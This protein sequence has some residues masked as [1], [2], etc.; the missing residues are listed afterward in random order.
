MIRIGTGY[1]VH[2]FTD[3]RP[4]VLGG[5]TIPFEKGLSGHSDARSEEHTSEL[6]SH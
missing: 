6:Q 3:G 2:A 5:V 4:L 1:D